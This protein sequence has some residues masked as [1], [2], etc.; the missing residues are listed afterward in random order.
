MQNP[1]PPSQVQNPPPP[2]HPPLSQPSPPVAP[3]AAFGVPATYTSA[4]SSSSSS[5]GGLY[6]ILD[7]I[8]NGSKRWKEVVHMVIFVLRSSFC[9]QLA[10]FYEW[11]GDTTHKTEEK[12]VTL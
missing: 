1:P 3:A 4:F 9:K 2:V 11:I 5:S 6:Q 12:L 8:Q 10:N 7:V